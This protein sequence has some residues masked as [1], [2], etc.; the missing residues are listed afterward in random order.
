MTAI[1]PAIPPVTHRRVLGIALPIAISNAAVPLLGAVD[2]AV[3]GRLGAVEVG[4]VGLGAI[5]L[6]FAFGI[7]NFLRMSTTGLVAQATGARDEAEA[8]AHLL[9]ALVLG[10][11]IGAAL[12]VAQGPVF[13]IGLGLAPAS[14]EVEA[15][16]RLYLGI[17]I[18]GMPA[19]IA[20]YAI[21]GWL[22]GIARTRAVLLL[23]LAMNGL[24]ALLSVFFVLGLGWGVAGCAAGTL[25]AEG[26]G[27]AL[28]LF[29]ARHALAQGWQGARGMARLF[30]R[31]R[32][33]RLVRVNGDIFIRSVLLQLSFASF[34]FL[35]ASQGDLQLAAN[36]VL[37]QLIE[38]TA[39]AL[40][41]FAFAAEALVGQAIGARSRAGVRRAALVSTQWG[42]AGA[43]AMSLAF[44]L[45]G[46]PLIDLL[47]TL[48]DLREAAR[49]FLPWVVVFPLVGIAAW[50]LDGIFI[51][52]TLTGEMRR[53]MLVAALGYAVCVAVALP[54]MGNAGLWLS[55][56]VLNSLRGVMMARWYPRA[57]TA[58]A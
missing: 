54:L 56:L 2:T 48:P 8:G 47:T 39:F 11:G 34:I 7:F 22:I 41:G 20:L 21:T 18:W 4:A 14:D 36:Q 38:L 32:V 19:T 52:A 31:D 10:L 25:I 53:A 33:A 16:A 58:A 3:M 42:V 35:S 17:R 27:L 13:R 50:M 28:G 6:A 49:A 29:L 15:A 12:V 24:N 1:A 43:L 40:D 57:E 46:G 5:I 51:G 23:Y 44:L 37:M 45:A 26:F 55:L 30:A 9:R